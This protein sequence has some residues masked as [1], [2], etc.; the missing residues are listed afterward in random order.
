LRR[1]ISSKEKR[2]REFQQQQAAFK[3]QQA[4]QMQLWAKQGKLNTFSAGFILNQES[5]QDLSGAENFFDSYDQQ[6]ERSK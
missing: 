5:V 4:A 2:E 1:S 3:A 6:Y